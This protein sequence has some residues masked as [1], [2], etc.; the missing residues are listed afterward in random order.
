MN[1]LENLRANQNWVHIPFIFLTARS[2]EQEI[3]KGRTSG[4]EQYLVKPVEP[5]QLIELVSTQ[6]ERSQQLAQ[7]HAG[8]LHQLKQHAIRALNHEFRTPLT[9]V[10]VLL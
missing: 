9:L 1:C 5:E 2:S 6:L 7:I 3:L 10:M 4:A 8:T